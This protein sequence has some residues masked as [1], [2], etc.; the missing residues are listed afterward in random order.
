NNNTEKIVNYLLSTYPHKKW[1]IDAGALQMLDPTLLNTNCIITPHE[2]ELERLLSSVIPVKARAAGTAESSI[3]RDLDWK[4]EQLLET[5]T[6]VLL[7]GH[8]D[9]VFNREQ[10]L[11][12]DGGNPGMT[13]GGTG[14][15]LAGLVAGLY[16]FTNDSFA[17]AV[18]GSY[19]NKQAGDHLY[20]QVGPFFKTTQ[21]V[22]EIPKV[23]KELLY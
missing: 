9:H 21:L 3:V 18:V 11:W 10:D 6:T 8:K 2:V 22:Q 4:Q 7:K 15:A 20:N 17:A 12:I 14:D 23:L 1:V 19:V 13:K 16:A 5:G